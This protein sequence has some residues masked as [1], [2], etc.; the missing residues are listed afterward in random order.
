MTPFIRDVGTKIP[1]YPLIILSGHKNSCSKMTDL[2]LRGLTLA[3]CKKTS[4]KVTLKLDFR[5]PKCDEIVRIAAI[6]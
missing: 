3:F 4:L 5:S 2:Y 6:L 1:V